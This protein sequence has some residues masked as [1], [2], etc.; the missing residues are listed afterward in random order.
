MF[1]NQFLEN[2]LHK[3]C[4][5]LQDK[6]REGKSYNSRGRI[7]KRVSSLPL[8]E[9]SNVQSGCSMLSL[10]LTFHFVNRIKRGGSVSL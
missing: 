4:Y 7:L 9:A 6:G 1:E 10:Q 3:D 5:K 8:N 2:E